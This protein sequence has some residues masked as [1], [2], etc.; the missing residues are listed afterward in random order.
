M[1]TAVMNLTEESTNTL[2]A[3]ETV[4]KS[5]SKLKKVGIVGGA[6]AASVAAAYMMYKVIKH[7]QKKLAA[8]DA[9]EDVVDIDDA[10]IRVVED[11]AE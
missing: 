1:E 2:E 10:K 9:E 8:K 7:V 3:V 6:A 4:A 5:G 11:D